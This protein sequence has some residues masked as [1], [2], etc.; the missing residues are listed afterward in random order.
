MVFFLIFTVIPNVINMVIGFACI[1]LFFSLTFNW[2]WKPR[3]KA[4]FKEYLINP[5]TGVFKKI[6]ISDK[7]LKENIKLIGVYKN[8]NLYEFNYIF[9]KRKTKHV[10]V[11]AQELFDTEYEDCICQ[12]ESGLYL[13]NY[14]KLN[15]YFE[16]KKLPYICNESTEK[17]PIERNHLQAELIQ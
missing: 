12:D 5:I 16:N 6:K 1:L 14:E 10:G 3:V 4:F 15:F 2:I 9:D 11:L 13:V 17:L 7:R 8:I